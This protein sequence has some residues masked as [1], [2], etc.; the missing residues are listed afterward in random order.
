[1]DQTP[2]FKPW[3]CQNG[4]HLGQVMRNGSGIRVLLLYRQANDP[5][6]STDA[7]PNVICQ[8]E[9]YTSD[10]Q[11]SLCSAVRRWVPG[12]ESINHLIER[13]RMLNK[14]KGEN[15]NGCE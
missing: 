2:Q 3:K 7:P 5:R 1:M 12:E 8:I 15:Q 14:R 11:C 4:H 6:N 10:I 9:G 13:A